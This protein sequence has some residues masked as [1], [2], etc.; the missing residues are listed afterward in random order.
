MFAP[1]ISHFPSIVF[2]P[3]HSLANL[4][5]ISFLLFFFFCC[6]L[7]FLPGS[8]SSFY[9]LPPFLLFGSSAVAP[10]SVSQEPLFP[11]L[12]RCISLSSP[13]TLGLSFAYRVCG[14]SLSAHQCTAPHSNLSSLKN[15]CITERGKKKKTYC[16]ALQGPLAC[17]LASGCGHVGV[18]DTQTSRKWLSLPAQQ[19]VGPLEQ[20]LTWTAVAPL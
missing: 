10:S 9:L 2:P 8:L 7:G 19:M 4:F 14:K 3:N 13:D 17:E 20:A 15:N 12:F 11:P 5:L 6:L 16:V 1:R 18:D